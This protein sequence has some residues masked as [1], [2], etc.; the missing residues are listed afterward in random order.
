MKKVCILIAVLFINVSVGVAQVSFKVN[1]KGRGEPVLLFPGFACPGEVWEETVK[2]LSKSYECHIFTFA[3]FGGVSAI[4]TP[5]FSTIK[6]EVKHYVK[7]NELKS[8]IILGHSLGGTLGLWLA[9]EEVQMFKKV[10]VVDGLPGAIALM[11]PAYKK[12]DKLTYNSPQST[13]QLEMSDEAFAEMSKQMASYMTLNMEKQSIISDWIKQADRK[14]YVYGY[15]DYLNADLRDE[16][17]KIKIPV[18][19]I[20][21]T[22]PSREIV[23]PNY[24]KQY[25]KLAGVKFEYVDNSAHFIMFDQPKVLLDKIHENIH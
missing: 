3:G 1:V 13:S 24:K 6:D 16:I 17:A 23:E 25:E 7:L 20:G 9:S 8:P 21:A 11:N 5:W 19:V 12:G 14:T 2:A 15:I 4:D 22:F 10:I 18:V